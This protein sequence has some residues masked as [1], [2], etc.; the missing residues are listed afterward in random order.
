MLQIVWRGLLWCWF[1]CTKG[2][3]QTYLITNI[4]FTDD[5]LC[6]FLSYKWDLYWHL[7]KAPQ[8]LEEDSHQVMN[9]DL[10]LMV[11]QMA[12]KMVMRGLEV[13]VHLA[14]SHLHLLVLDIDPRHLIYILGSWGGFGSC[15]LLG[16]WC[17]RI[18]SRD[19]CIH[20][21]HI[22]G[23]ILAIGPV[24]SIHRQRSFPAAAR[25]SNP[26]LVLELGISG[27]S[28][29]IILLGSPPGVG[30]ALA[31]HKFWQGWWNT[32][33]VDHTLVY[34]LIWFFKIAVASLGLTL[35]LAFHAFLQQC[36][37]NYIKKVS[38]WCFCDS[39][40][41][42]SLYSSLLLFSSFIIC[43]SFVRLQLVAC[44]FRLT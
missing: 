24:V 15:S 8:D 21:F 37:S 39:F 3:L 19:L 4:L 17:P 31:G 41:I 30:W 6:F 22:L 1:E 23:S 38:K 36:W 34:N 20:S 25:S 28:S 44:C 7:Q 10:H 13:V 32:S 16:S 29:C 35:A 14:G 42:E 18:L 27:Q 5:T 43:L 11:L 2:F 26:I 9:G 33:I 12:L 40:T